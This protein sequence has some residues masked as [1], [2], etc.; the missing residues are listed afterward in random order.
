LL[1]QEGLKIAQRD[2]KNVAWLENISKIGNSYVL[3]E[4]PKHYNESMEKVG[5]IYD[6]R[7]CMLAIGT[8]SRLSKAIEARRMRST[9]FP[10]S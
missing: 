8:S 6:F 3:K 4:V 9:R 10:L 7:V 5:R 1:Q 2:I